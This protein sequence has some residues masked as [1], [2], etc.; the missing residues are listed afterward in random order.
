MQ[1]FEWLRNEVYPAEED[2]WQN[3]VFFSDGSALDSGR[4]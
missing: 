1:M 3:K 4:F 2:Q